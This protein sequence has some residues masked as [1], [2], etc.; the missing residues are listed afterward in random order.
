MVFTIGFCSFS[1][2]ITM[3]ITALQDHMHSTNSSAGECVSL[4]TTAA[5]SSVVTLLG[6]LSDGASSSI[7]AVCSF[8]F[9]YCTSSNFS[10][11][12]ISVWF[13]WC[14]DLCECSHQPFFSS[15]IRVWP[16]R[17]HSSILFID[18]ETF[19]CWTLQKSR[20]RKSQK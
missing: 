7:T 18:D 9:T 15:A 6:L 17:L 10:L 5:S 1:C 4:A 16:H 13:P 12:A 8:I 3:T 11:F 20:F 2:W 19:C 14:H